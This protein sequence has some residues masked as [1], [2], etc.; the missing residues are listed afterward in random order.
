[1]DAF[2]NWQILATVAGATAATKFI[3]DAVKALTNIAGK[4]VLV[5]AMLVGIGI[6]VLANYSLGQCKPIDLPLHA[7][8]G[9]IVGLA[10]SGFNDLVSR[11]K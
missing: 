11:S 6:V 4:Q 10:A 1:V 8:N 9:L 7:I 3:V 2:V 5:C